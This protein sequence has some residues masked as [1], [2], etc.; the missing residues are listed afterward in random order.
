MTRLLD[1]TWRPLFAVLV[2]VA[3]VLATAAVVPLYRDVREGQRQITALRER[4]RDLGGDPDVVNVTVRP[5]GPVPAASPTTRER[6]PSLAPP[7]RIPPT[8]PSAAP[9]PSPSATPCLL[10]IVP[11]CP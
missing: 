11:V 5:A 9:K 3:L 7:Q 6:P 8:S 4:V 1:R 10:P 2:G